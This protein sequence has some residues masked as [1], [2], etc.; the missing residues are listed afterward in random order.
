M[1]LQTVRA[2]LRWLPTR[3]RSAWAA[4]AF[5]SIAVMLFELLA[6]GAVY[7]MVDRAARGSIESSLLGLVAA[8]FLAR[9]LL[10]WIVALL[11]SRVVS[12]SIA[13]V[14]DRLLAGY[15]GAPFQFHLGRSSAERMQRL[16]TAIDTTYRLVMAAVPA[17]AGELMVMIGLTA[18]IVVIAPFRAAVAVAVLAAAG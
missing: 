18:L 12:G 15:L 1:L 2:A 4:L 7:R 9:S 14:F 8:V 13:S 16:T 5:L 3:L 6:A 17:L 10:L 11:Q